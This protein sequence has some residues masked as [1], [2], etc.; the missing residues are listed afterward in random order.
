MLEQRAGGLRPTVIPGTREDLP[1]NLDDL[2]LIYRHT[3]SSFAH[4]IFTATQGLYYGVEGSLSEL[5]RIADSI[6]VKDIS[7]IGNTLAILT[8]SGLQYYLFA[9]TTYKPIGSKPSEIDMS[10]GLAARPYYT[11]GDNFTAEVSQTTT[12]AFPLINTTETSEKVWAALNQTFIGKEFSAPFFV[13]AAYRMNDDSHHMATPPVLMIPD[14]KGPRALLAD[15]VIENS[16]TKRTIKGKLAVHG[17][18]SS[19]VYRIYSAG[20]LADWKDVISGVDI[21]VSRIVYPYEVGAEIEFVDSSNRASF[22]IYRDSVDGGAYEQKSF[23]L[24]EG[25]AYFY[26]P[27]KSEKD[28]LADLEGASQFYKIAEFTLDEFLESVNPNYNEL[29]KP[30]EGFTVENLT[31]QD[32]L[33]DADDYQSHD[34]IIAGRAFAYNRRLHLYELQRTL[35]QGFKPEVMWPYTDNGTTIY[36]IAV[37]VSSPDGTTKVVKTTSKVNTL[38]PV[39]RFLYYPDANATRMVVYD[40]AGTPVFDFSLKPHPFLNGAYYAWIDN[41]SLTSSSTPALPDSANDTLVLD[42][43]LYVSEADNPYRFPLKS[44]YTIGTGSI[45]GLSTIATALSQGQFGQF[46]LMAFCTDGKY[47]LS[48]GDEGRYS[49]IHPP[50]SRDIC[51][52]PRSITQTDSE[53]M[54]VTSKGVMITSGASA[55]LLSADLDGVPDTFAGEAPDDA[56]GTE[57]P[58][59]FFAHCRIVYDYANRRLFFVSIGSRFAYVYS[60]E[61]ASWSTVQLDTVQSVLN[62]YPYSYIQMGGKLVQLDQPYP[63]EGE[64]VEGLIVT[65]PVKFDSLQYKVLHQITLQGVFASPQVIKVFGSQDG[66]SWHYLGKSQTRRIGRMAGRP[67]KYF[68][69]VLVTTLSPEEN[70]TGLRVGY[71]IRAERRLR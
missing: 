63:Y 15:A 35:F 53:T 47:S 36:T 30:T 18:V 27:W 5:T 48:V 8:P 64:E 43:K 11:S 10:F 16:G 70:I 38:A 29:L 28:Y 13:R 14:S 34:T 68:R 20:N 71:D 7:S 59:D 52:N 12:G 2:T 54:F 17:I 56:V 57:K 21:F 55:S 67:F 60:I 62:A 50:T 24:Y 39:P 61:T 31:L 58:I 44:I 3:T 45:I 37:W 1:T 41:R 66:I 46:P 42:N 49:F 19:L 33:D 4:L 25:C 9:E 69:F 32:T 23:Q 65:R 40:E 51:I 26:M 6:E 22:G